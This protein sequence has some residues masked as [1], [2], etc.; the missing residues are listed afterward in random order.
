[1][2]AGSAFYSHRLAKQ[3]Y[4]GAIYQYQEL[5]SYPGPGTNQTQTHA[6]LL[7]Y[8]YYPTTRFSVSFFG[9]P[10]YYSAG[11]QYS[12][13]LPT[14][15]ASQ[16]W[17]PAGGASISWQALHSSL[18]ASYL[19]GVSDGGGLIG[20]VELDSAVASVRQGLTHHLSAGFSGI[21]ANNGVLAFAALGGHSVSGSASLRQQVGEHLA[22]EAGYTRLHQ[23]YSFFAAN[24][25]TNREWISISYQFAKLLGR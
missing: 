1:L 22:L 15:A 9:G 8:T 6:V 17:S 12:P 24:P 13:T 25:D 16:S 4:A 7:F 20:A 2:R 23:T 21:Y 18:A 5:L 19:H 10:Q 11:P 14:V 3:H